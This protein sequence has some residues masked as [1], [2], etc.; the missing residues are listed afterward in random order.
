MNPSPAPERLWQPTAARVEHALL[1]DYRRWLARTHGLQF[2]DYEA[3]WEW[4]VRELD[5]FWRSVW[6]YFGLPGEAPP[7]VALADRRMPGMKWFPDTR[8]NFTA[9]VFRHAREGVPALVYESEGGHVEEVPWFEL[10]R[11]VAALAHTLQARGVRAGDRVVGYLPNVPEAAVALL[12]CASLGAIW[13]VAAPDMGPRSVIDRFRQIEPVAMIACDGSRFGGAWRDRV[14]ALNEVLAALPTVR[15][16]LLVSHAD[17]D[18]ADPARLVLP[19]GATAM[20]FEQACAGV[21]AFA[22]AEL[23]FDHPLWIVYS[24]GTTGLPKAIVHGHG[25]IVLETLVG[26][27]L[28]SDVHPGDRMMWMSSTGWIVWNVQ[29]ASLLAGATVVLTD[30]SAS[31]P[32]WG[33]Y[34]RLVARHRV[35]L[36]GAGAAFLTQ[37]M[38]NGVKPREIAD[39]ARLRSLGATGSPLPAEVYRWA[40]EQVSSDLHLMVISGGTDIAGAF[41]Q[42][43]PTLPIYA[44]EM[45]CRA[46]GAAVYAFNERGEP[47]QGEVGELVCTEPL[48]SMPLRF[49]GDADHKRY[50]ES[51]FDSFQHR[52]GRHIWRHGDWMQLNARREAVGAVIYGRSDATVNRHGLRLGTAEIYRVVEADEAVHDS[53]VIDLEYLGKPSCLLLFVVLSKGVELDAAVQSRLREAV[54]RDVSPRFEPDEIHAVPE[55]PRTLTGKK[56]ELPLRKLLLG[57]PESQVLQRDAIGNPGSLQWFTQ[58]ARVRASRA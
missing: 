57:Q 12:A 37:C 30:A 4:S 39:L 18:P 2:D 34:W 51:Y 17:G 52:D 15:S 14:D 6:V 35:D 32:D 41:I 43:A 27:A 46:L 7:R 9:E 47:V 1:T 31:C 16:V 33:A 50:T 26:T 11:R 44:G 55:V 49:W 56:L 53:L 13:S 5:A 42:C 21:V 24:S 22:P 48:P 29:I 40:Y 58:F 28:H 45:Q 54:R 20:P 36:F 23:P 3:L 10:Q 25:G 19:A 8:I 38:K